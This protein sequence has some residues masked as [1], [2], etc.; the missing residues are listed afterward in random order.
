M[1]EQQQ[2]PKVQTSSS[3]LGAYFQQYV[4][5]D[6]AVRNEEANARPYERKNEHI[7][8]ELLASPDYS[9][10]RLRESTWDMVRA[11]KHVGGRLIKSSL[12]YDPATYKL[13]VHDDANSHVY[14]IA[15]ETLTR[16]K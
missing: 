13:L 11:R 9:R 1:E 7:A 16:S 10:L 4:V 8:N 6:N 15:P 12:Q 5:H 14:Y 2:Q 3:I